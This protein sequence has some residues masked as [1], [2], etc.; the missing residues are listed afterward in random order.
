[1]FLLH[2]F[3]LDPAHPVNI[4]GNGKLVGTGILLHKIREDFSVNTPLV[5]AS[6]LPKT[7]TFAKYVKM[8]AGSVITA[9]VYKAGKTYRLKKDGETL[10]T[11]NI[12]E[13]DRKLGTCLSYG[14]SLKSKM[15]SWKMAT[16]LR[17]I[18]S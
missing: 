14:I 18:P 13:P 5:I 8:E 16:R 9:P 15:S 11:V 12:T 17:R 4:S 6:N 2:G 3:S 10:Y 1:M 7:T